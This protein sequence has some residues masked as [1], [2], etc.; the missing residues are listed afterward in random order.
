MD[1]IKFLKNLGMTEYE[2]RIY[3][4]LSKLGPSAARAITQHSKVPKNKTYE[5]LQ[6]LE[7]KNMIMTLPITPRQYKVNNIEKLKDL[8]SEKKQ[9]LDNLKKGFKEF[10]KKAETQSINEFREI[11]WIIKTQK[12]IQERLA[13]EDT[14][15]RKEVVSVNR[16]SKYLPK[17]LRAI[18][19]MIKRRVKV[20]MICL[21]EKD[22]YK[23]VRRY[24]ETGA[25]VRVFNKKLFGQVLPKFTV[26][27]K[28]ILRITIGRPEIKKSEDYLSFLFESP[29]FANVF[30][31]YFYN[32]WDK[33]LNVE[34]ELKKFEKYS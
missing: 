4:A 29:S 7:K 14:K 10:A 15:T 6:K 12:A 30:R 33:C 23:N 24:I 19:E 18:K 13:Y 17:N 34:A 2:A 11:V 26:F 1:E 31:N 22:N 9:E 25:E 28:K 20:K 3:S 21:V 27:D 16:L 5:T 8:I 32:M